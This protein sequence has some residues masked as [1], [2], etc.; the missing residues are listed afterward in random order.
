MAAVRF[1]PTAQRRTF[2]KMDDPHDWA[3][4]VPYNQPYYLFSPDTQ[5]W[6]PV[7][8]STQTQTQLS[9]AAPAPLDKFEVLSW[10]IDFMRILDDERMIAALNHLR[11]HVDPAEADQS[12]TVASVPKVIMLNEMTRSDL[13]LI[14]G[15]DWIREG[16]HVTD[17]ST[18]YWESE[19][20][21][22]LHLPKPRYG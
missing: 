12:A 20:Y 13:I 5:Q 9:S 2:F 11:T 15:Q 7:T 3:R 21:G 10:N 6:Q 1:D 17:I 8:P 16:Y 22:T 14:Q 4:G 18:E 19:G